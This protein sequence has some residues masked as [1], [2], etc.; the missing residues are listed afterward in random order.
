MDRDNIASTNNVAPRLSFAFAPIRDGR[1]VIRG[2]VGLFYDQIDLNVA[3]F[4]QMQERLIT[5]YG[6]DGRQ[7]MGTQLQRMALQNGAYLT[8]RSV[9]WN[10][11]VDREWLKDLFVRVGYRQRQGTREFTLDPINSSTSGG[12]LSLSNAGKSRYREL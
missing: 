1:T 11:E 9:N 7:V 10:I 12:I 8:P 5:L 6:A 3:T 2:G 4:P